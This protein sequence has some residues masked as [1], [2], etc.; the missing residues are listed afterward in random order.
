ME[1]RPEGFHVRWITHFQGG[2]NPD[3]GNQDGGLFGNPNWYVDAGQSQPGGWTNGEVRHV[4]G[5]TILAEFGGVQIVSIPQPSPGD[6]FTATRI[7]IWT[8]DPRDGAS[9]ADRRKAEGRLIAEE[10]DRLVAGG[11]SAYRDGRSYAI[12]GG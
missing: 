5:A 9:A 11:D 2:G 1:A 4:D 12:L 3:G 6:G 10:I 7:E 8:V